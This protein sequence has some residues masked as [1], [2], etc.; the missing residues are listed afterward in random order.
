MASLER[1]VIEQGI[2][3]WLKYRKVF[4]EMGI[5]EYTYSISVQVELF[6]E[7]IKEVEECAENGEFPWEIIDR[8]DGDDRDIPDTSDEGE[9]EP[10]P[11]PAYYAKEY[12]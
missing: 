11:E 3:S 5:S 8:E 9:Y 6:D 7:L 4:A 12:F 10:F 2:L 1:R